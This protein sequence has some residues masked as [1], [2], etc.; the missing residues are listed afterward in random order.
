MR[1]YLSSYKFGNEIGELL[2]LSPKSN[3]RIALIANA[4]DYSTDLERRKNGE[5]ENLNDLKKLGFVPEIVDLRHYFGKPAELK[6]VIA[7]YGSVFVRGGNAFVLRQ[8]MKLSGFDEI[9]NGLVLSKKDFLYAGYSA[10]VCV[11]APSLKGLDLVDDVTKKPYGN[12][13]TIFEG[14]NLVNYLIVPHYKSNHPESE[15]M[16]KV[17]EYCV[18]NKIL[19]KVLM[20]GEVIIIK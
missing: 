10:G 13:D 3:N 12:I 5:D 19:F 1:F 8:A 7:T 16:N 14:L 18:G 6:K 17:V 4:L 2:G 9:L 15:A 20:D 11:L